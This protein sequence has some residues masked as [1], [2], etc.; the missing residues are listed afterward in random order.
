MVFVPYALWLH[1]SRTVNTDTRENERD[2]A[3]GMGKIKMK[4]Y[5]KLDLFTPGLNLAIRLF[6]N[7][8]ANLLKRLFTS[9]YNSLFLSFSPLL[10][11][12][13]SLCGK[14]DVLLSKAFASNVL[15]IIFQF[16]AYTHSFSLVKL[17]FSLKECLMKIEINNDDRYI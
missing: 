8:T 5:Q 12:F 2:E 1:T 15:R 17:R 3:L 13:E 6:S 14:V 11:L 4:R 10:L 16:V 9:H 7:S